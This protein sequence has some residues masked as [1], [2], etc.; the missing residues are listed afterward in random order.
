MQVVFTAWTDESKK[1][2]S[3]LVESLF[4]THFSTQK[5]LWKVYL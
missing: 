4:L 1:I 3:G 5:Y 2:N